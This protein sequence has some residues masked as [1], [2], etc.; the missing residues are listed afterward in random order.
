MGS[1]GQSLGAHAAL[2][3]AAVSPPPGEGQAFVLCQ[4]IAREAVLVPGGQ[5]VKPGGAAHHMAPAPSALHQVL[6]APLAVFSLRD[7][8]PLVLLLEGYQG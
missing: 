7:V 3:I 8:E 4:V 1:Y 5:P 2:Q 6:H